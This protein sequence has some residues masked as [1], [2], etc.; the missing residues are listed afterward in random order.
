M[1]TLFG[2]FGALLAG[3][4]AE[5]ALA[6]TEPG[7]AKGDSGDEDDGDQ[8]MQ[9]SDEVISPD[10]YGDPI[11]SD[12]IPDRVDDPV[13]R[14]GG[15]GDDLMRGGGG[16]DTIAG[17]AG[18]DQIDA[19]GG[20]D[21]LDGGYGDDIIW[22]EEGD[23][24]LSG[25]AGDDILHGQDGNDSL[26]GGEGG[27]LSTLIAAKRRTSAVSRSISPM[28]R[29]QKETA[30]G[31]VPV[32]PSSPVQALASSGARSGRPD[33][34]SVGISGASGERRL[35]SSASAFTALPRTCGREEVIAST[36]KCTRPCC[37]SSSACA[38]PR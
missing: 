17:G 10:D 31:G 3:V 2:L 36:M 6:V 8:R 28:A 13:V 9:S 24:T 32:G 11:E 16:A 14:Q 29:F 5:A 20:D 21:E 25:G 18:D 12:D 23:D 22:A 38:E 37:M 34:A 30:S 7:A 19:G 33:S 15:D 4:L 1:L 26:S 27:A 35:T